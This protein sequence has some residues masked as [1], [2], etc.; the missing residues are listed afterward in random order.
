MFLPGKSDLPLLWLSDEE[1][2]SMPTV[3]G[4]A[5]VIDIRGIEMPKSKEFGVDVTDP[6]V[7]SFVLKSGLEFGHVDFDVPHESPWLDAVASQR[8]VGLLRGPDPITYPSLVHALA[9]LEVIAAGVVLRMTSGGIS[10]IPK[11][12]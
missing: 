1:L 4:W 6:L 9:H 11:T 10:W 7:I 3:E 8:V 2:T 12:G 5:R